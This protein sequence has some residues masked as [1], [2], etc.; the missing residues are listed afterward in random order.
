MLLFV[1]FDKGRYIIFYIDIDRSIKFHK[2]AIATIFTDIQI[3]GGGAFFSYM[4]TLEGSA[5]T[6]MWV[7]LGAAYA[8]SWRYV[9]VIYLYV[10]VYVCMCIYRWHSDRAC[11]IA[12][13]RGTHLLHRTSVIIIMAPISAETT[14][15]RPIENAQPSSP[16]ASETKVKRLRLVRCFVAICICWSNFRRWGFDQELGI[17][18]D[19][20]YCVRCV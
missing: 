4:S 19:W 15:T 20:L 13:S 12:Q 8:K 11:Q 9:I 7:L 6:L 14:E 2:I 3:V 5:T 17:Y 10:Y 1:R 16:A 18:V